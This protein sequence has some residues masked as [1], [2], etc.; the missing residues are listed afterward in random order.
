MA[1]E[2]GIR[3]LL[4]EHLGVSAELIDHLQMI[5]I[6]LALG[7]TLGVSFPLYR[8]RHLVTYRDLLRVARD[9][10]H[11][12]LTHDGD[13]Y[14]RARL[15]AADVNL[16]RVG[17]L[18]PTFA[19]ALADDL[20][21]APAGATLDIAVPDDF[22]DGELVALH[23]RLAWMLG[24]TVPLVVRRAIDLGPD[25]AVTWDRMTHAH[26]KPRLCTSVLQ[27][28]GDGIAIA[29]EA[30]DQPLERRRFPA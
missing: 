20:R 23:K 19:A 9:A 24:A 17:A 27:R 30:E 1:T 10:L 21:H 6:A 28:A 26:P 15:K 11:D 12:Q 5:D 14:V 2:H 25:T 13:F 18:N 22:S 29:V 3:A 7:E 4:V 16:V 8:L